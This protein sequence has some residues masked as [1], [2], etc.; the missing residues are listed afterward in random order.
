MATRTG[1]VLIVPVGHGKASAEVSIKWRDSPR[2]DK[3]IQARKG[4]ALW[5]NDFYKSEGGVFVEMGTI[6]PSDP[7]G[8]GSINVHGV[9]THEIAVLEDRPKPV[10]ALEVLDG[11]PRE[12]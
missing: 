6:S 11:D 5:A 10:E 9:K 1:K 12:R 8:K 7:D 3:A 4:A 2:A